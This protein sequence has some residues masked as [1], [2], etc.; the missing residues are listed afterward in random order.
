TT[1][2]AADHPVS[3]GQRG[4]LG[5]RGSDPR[6]IG[7]RG[8]G[9]SPINRIFDIILALTLAVIL[10]FPAL[11]I[12]LW[13]LIEEGRP[14]FYLSKRMRAPNRPFLLWKFRTMKLAAAD[15]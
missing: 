12:A 8:G 14:V 15:S 9:M 7:P 13:L 4:A 3:I 5:P 1:A 6:A 11:I 2:L 10:L